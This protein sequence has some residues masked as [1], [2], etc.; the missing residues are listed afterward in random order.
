M[1][2]VAQSSGNDRR[3]TTTTGNSG[4]TE[5]FGGTSSASPLAAGVI[6]LMLEANP[7]LTW[8]DV[9]HV[10]INSTRI[11]DPS[12]RRLGRERRRTSG[13]LQLRLRR[14]RRRRQ[15]SLWPPTGPA[16]APKIDVASETV[17]VDQPLPDNDEGGFQTGVTIDQNIRIESVELIVNATTD[18]VGDLHIALTAPSGTESILALPRS[19]P[20]DNYSNYLFTSLRHWDES[21]A[22]QWTVRISDQ[23]A[24][25][26]AFW[27][28]FSLLIHGTVGLTGDLNCDGTIDFD[29]ID[30]F[31]AALGGDG[32]YYA[33]YP[34]CNRLLADIN[35]DGNINFDDIDPFVALLGG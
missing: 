18:Y 9:Q 32:T 1:L 2:A 33:E 26:A 25:N 4:Y 14:H 16:P 28:D 3:I 20:N 12:A 23:Q 34:D 7:S 11:C 17:I 31:I 24:G 22:G 19:D 10:L 21:S 30:P 6:A 8:R 13:Q 27:T 29:D 15:P 35:G 5:Y